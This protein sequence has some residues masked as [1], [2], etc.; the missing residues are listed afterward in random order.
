[1]QIIGN[2]AL[3][4]RVRNPDPILA[5]IPRSKIVKAADGVTEIAVKW[6]LEEAQ[7]LSQL[8]IKKVPSPIQRDYD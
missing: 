4:L 6:G 7:M 3:L 5:T 8:R 1:M 2:K